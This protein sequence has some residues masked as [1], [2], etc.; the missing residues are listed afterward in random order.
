MEK[1]LVVAFERLQVLFIK[2]SFQFLLYFIIFNDICF[3]LEPN[4]RSSTQNQ[5]KRFDNNFFFYVFYDELSYS[6]PC[7]S[8]TCKF[9]HYYGLNSNPNEKYKE[10]FQQCIGFVRDKINFKKCTYFLDQE[11]NSVRE[12]QTLYMNE[13]MKRED[14]ISRMKQCLQNS[15]GTNDALKVR[16]LFCQALIFYRLLIY[17]DNY[18]YQIQPQY[19]LESNGHMQI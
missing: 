1:G 18:Q 12:T 14:E 13:V 2:F 10:R 4:I 16:P 11:I 15:E 6:R 8:S 5:R 9:Q 19:H 17:P 3:H 7:W